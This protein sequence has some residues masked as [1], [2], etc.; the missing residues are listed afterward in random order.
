V[1][2]DLEQDLACL[3]AS[4]RV[5]GRVAWP[6]GV[7]DHVRARLGPGDFQVGLSHA[8]DVGDFRLEPGA[9][10]VP[11]EWHRVRRGGQSELE[12]ASLRDEHPDSQERNI[13]VT[14]VRRELLRERLGEAVAPGYSRS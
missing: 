14:R 6:V 13:V 10:A 4:A 5:E 7:P 8:I 12:S 2:A 11:R 1:V 9:Q 3:D